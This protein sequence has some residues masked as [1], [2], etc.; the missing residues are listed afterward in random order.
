MVEGE[1][2]HYERIASIDGLFEVGR[3]ISGIIV[4]CTMPGES[5]AG[6]LVLEIN[7]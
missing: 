5:I 6:C 3:G 7:G 1:I 4:S 2:E